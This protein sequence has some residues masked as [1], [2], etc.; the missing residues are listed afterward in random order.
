M[1]KI[2]AIFLFACTFSYAQENHGRIPSKADNKKIHE[3]AKNYGINMSQV[4]VRGVEFSDVC[5]N[6]IVEDAETAKL[7]SFS[8]DVTSP[9]IF[10][11]NNLLKNSS[12]MFCD[13][14]I[15][16]I[17]LGLSRYKIDGYT[18]QTSVRFNEKGN[19][20]ECILA[21]EV[22]IEGIMVPELTRVFH[23]D[24]KFLAIQ[25]PWDS[26]FMNLENGYYKIRNGKTQKIDE[27]LLRCW[28]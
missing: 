28:N 7:L 3:T 6:G 1:I 26:N 14:K 9:I 22:K 2:T 16:G 20:C 12:F 8:L 19:L 27:D 11:S 25:I 4:K 21:E 5:N 15:T 18:C 10:R 13:G 23:K 24:N 17:N